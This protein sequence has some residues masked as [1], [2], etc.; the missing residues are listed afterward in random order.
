MK[1]DIPILQ[2]QVENGKVKATVTK[3]PK[4]TTP[5]T[6]RFQSEKFFSCLVE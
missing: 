4:P 5:L 6:A 3:V 1:E 2:R